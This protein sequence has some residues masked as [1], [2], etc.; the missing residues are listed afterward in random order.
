MTDRLELFHEGL[1]GLAWAFQVNPSSC[2]NSGHYEQY[3]RLVALNDQT[4]G[5][6]TTH[7]F[8][9]NEN[10]KDRILGFITL[11][12]T[13][14]IKTYENELRG[15]PALE[16]LELAVAKDYEHQGIGST[17]V[18]YAFTTAFDLNAETLGIQ[19]VLLCADEQAEGFYRTFGF[20]RV[21][22]HDSVPRDGWN[23]HC[24]PMFIKLSDLT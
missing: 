10:G 8:I 14:F 4:S 5:R 7:V 21:E 3:L 22:D 17:L 20:E 18:K 9:R 19:Y 16:I 1:V 12:A 2:G 6:G 13:S 15:N 11:R 23:V 24:V